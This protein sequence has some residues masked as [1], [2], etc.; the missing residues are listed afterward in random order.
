MHKRRIAGGMIVGI[1]SGIPGFSKLSID[2]VLTL[3]SK[4]WEMES[5]R[6][7]RKCKYTGVVARADALQGLQESYQQP[8]L[9]TYNVLCRV[10]GISGCAARALGI[11][12]WD[13][14]APG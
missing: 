9:C 8:T 3:G 10:G 11:L 1:R 6:L 14:G 2:S 12:R 5:G 4:G 13:R 7:C